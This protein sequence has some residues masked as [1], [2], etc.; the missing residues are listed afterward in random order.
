[1]LMKDV[2]IGKNVS[3]TNISYFDYSIYE[4]RHEKFQVVGSWFYG[5]S[6][7]TFFKKPLT[8]LGT[9]NLPPILN[10]M[11]SRAELAEANP[12]KEKLQ[13]GK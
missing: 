10:G 1:M 8:L 4:E 12:I 9:L 3:H 11:P 5:K 7:I 6:K 2:M 13:K